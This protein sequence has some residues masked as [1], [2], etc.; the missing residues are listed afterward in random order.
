[1]RHGGMAEQNLYIVEKRR[2]KENGGRG[3]N[4]YRSRFILLVDPVSFAFNEV[5]GP[6][7]VENIC[8]YIVFTLCEMPA[9]SYSAISPK[10]ESA[11]DADILDQ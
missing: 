11:S 1:M 5:F 6:N 10:N 2:R 8:R 3:K 7:L 9:A 4:C